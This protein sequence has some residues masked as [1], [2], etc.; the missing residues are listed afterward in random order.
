MQTHPTG[1]CK[2]EV[3]VKLTD[4]TERNYDY[5]CEP[6]GFCATLTTCEAPGTKQRHKDQSALI[7][8][9]NLI[10][11]VAP[12]PAMTNEELLD[13]SRAALNLDDST[14]EHL[15]VDVAFIDGSEIEATERKGFAASWLHQLETSGLP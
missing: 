11:E 4:G 3:D 14:I 6:D 5:H 9:G 13:R 8:L 7:A 10:A 2:F 12:T 15:N 1:I